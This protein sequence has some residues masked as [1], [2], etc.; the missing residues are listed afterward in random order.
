MVEWMS[1]YIRKEKAPKAKKTNPEKVQ[2]KNQLKTSQTPKRFQLEYWPLIPFAIQ[3][4]KND[5]NN[6]VRS[7][8]AYAKLAAIEKYKVDQYRQMLLAYQSP[9]TRYLRNAFRDEMR[10]LCTDRTIEFSD[11]YLPIRRNVVLRTYVTAEPTE[12]PTAL[13]NIEATHIKTK[14]TQLVVKYRNDAIKALTALEH[15][16]CDTSSPQSTHAPPKIA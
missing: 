3:D 13:I 11:H 1:N 16:S 2:R 4:W 14:Q 6:R 7:F 15:L 5:S 8:T 10:N 12:K 9:A